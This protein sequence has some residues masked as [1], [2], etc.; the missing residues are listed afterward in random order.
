MSLFVVAILVLNA[1][2]E[3]EI[4]RQLKVKSINTPVE[5]SVYR[6]LNSK[7]QKMIRNDKEN[8]IVEQCKIVEAN[9]ITNWT[10]DLYEGIRN[11]AK[12]FKPRDAGA[13][14]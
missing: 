14:F 6:M 7:I 11:I 10:K 8:F 5:S 13:Y 1:I 2:K 12:Q 9:R 4:R 3:V